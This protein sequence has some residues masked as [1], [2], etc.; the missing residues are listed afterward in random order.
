VLHRYDW[1]E[2]SLILDV[3]TR[4]QGRITVVAKGAK[5]PYSQLRSVLLPFQKLHISLSK[6][7]KNDDDTRRDIQNLQTL[8]GAEWAGGPAMLTG[9]A[10]FSGFY[11]NELLMKLLT[12]HDPQPDLFDI[13]AQTLPE[14]T[15]QNEQQAQ[16]ALRAFEIKLLQALGVLPDFSVVTQTQQA[17]SL[18]QR[19]ALR[20]EA[21]V[22]PAPQLSDAETLTGHSLINLQAAVQHGS[23][24]ALQQAC[25]TSLLPLKTGLRA[26]IQQQLGHSVLHTRQVLLSLQNL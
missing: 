12:S 14:L 3:L 17:V 11:V 13:Y 10:L 2:S 24:P 20:S 4:E 1:S 25:R 19:Y 23:L 7:S 21:G 16:A 6:P 22:A 8:R 15:A 5:R 18:A 26:V 9:A